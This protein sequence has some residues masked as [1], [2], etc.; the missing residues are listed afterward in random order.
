M[1][2]IVKARAASMINTARKSARKRG[3]KGRVD[4]SHFLITKTDIIEKFKE[5]NYKCFY[6]G[7]VLSYDYNLDWNA[8]LERINPSLGYTKE[9]IAITA[10]ELNGSC[11]WSLDKIKNM[12]Y[13]RNAPIDLEAL[14]ADINYAK[15]NLKEL[16]GGNKNAKDERQVVL[17][18]D[19]T[20][21]LLFCF[22]CEKM[23]QPCEFSK[24]VN[25]LGYKARCK[26]CLKTD[27]KYYVGYRPYLLSLHRSCISSE[28]KL[29]PE[30]FDK[31]NLITFEELL[32]KILDQEGRCY[33]SNI[34][35]KF[36][37]KSDWKCSI[38]RINNNFGHT[39][40]NTILVVHEFNTTKQWSR[41]KFLEFF[42]SCQESGK[43]L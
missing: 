33:Y 16:N 38:E 17:N 26:Q 29:R 43:F 42:R 4:A 8:S 7:L 35:L 39:N 14:I 2:D 15:E 12:V 20:I 24:G 10:H 6:S 3:Q 40:E 28:K 32:L 34:P 5:Q 30:G 9:N 41:Q 18:Q 27:R 23:L 36:E 25:K 22:K 1:E 11:Q 31:T 21:N 13:A 19:G 37:H